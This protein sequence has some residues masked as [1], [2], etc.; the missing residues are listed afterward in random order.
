MTQAEL[1]YTKLEEASGKIQTRMYWAIGVV[2]SVAGFLL[3]KNL[4]EVRE[5]AE[6]E[7]KK[8][9]TTIAEATAKQAV[10][11]SFKE[12]PIRDTVYDVAKREIGAVAQKEIGTAVSLIR[13][14]SKTLVR[15]STHL[16]RLRMGADISVLQQLREE[17]AQKDEQMKAMVEELIVA[18]G[19]DLKSQAE[20]A[21]AN[22]KK[23]TE[24]NYW[25][26]V[27]FLSRSDKER[28]AKPLTDD[29]LILA[30]W[31]KAVKPEKGRGSILHNATA[32]H[33]MNRLAGQNFP[34]LDFEAVMKWGLA[35]GYKLP[36]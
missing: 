27:A 17:T 19:E 2:L 6:R 35:R 12:K 29:E 18:L 16:T 22:Q 4:K 31:S 30:L 13:A 36:N 3:R 24:R 33:E 25:E 8:I 21:F 20:A 34:V 7:S 28:A 26:L 32:V 9:A 11:D 5:D 14:E 15:I 23:G 10:E 1:H